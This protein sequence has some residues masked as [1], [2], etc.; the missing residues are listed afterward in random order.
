M[1][2]KSIPKKKNLPKYLNKGDHYGSK[3][4]H[5]NSSKNL[6]KEIENTQKEKKSRGKKEVPEKKGAP[7]KS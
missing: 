1:F 2:Q 4:P 5:Q 3:R 7:K 6:G